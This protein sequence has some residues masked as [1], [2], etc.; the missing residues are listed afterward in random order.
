MERFVAIQRFSD[1]A[2][3]AIQLLENVACCCGLYTLSVNVPSPAVGGDDPAPR[4][5]TA[6]TPIPSTHNVRKPSEL[7]FVKLLSHR[8]GKGDRVSGG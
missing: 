4:R 3:L 2:V 5:L 6:C 1:S 7:H 8:R